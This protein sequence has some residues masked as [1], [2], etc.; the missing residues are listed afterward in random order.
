ML[1]FIEQLVK[2]GFKVTFESNPWK[3]LCVSIGRG[4]HTFS[5][6]SMYEVFNEERIVS[7]LLKMRKNIEQVEK[8]SQWSV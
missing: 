8:K 7:E 1:S 6:V 5:Y 3:C 2:D 4:E